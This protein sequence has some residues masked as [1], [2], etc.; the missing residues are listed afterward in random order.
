MTTTALPHPTP[1][2]LPV[3]WHALPHFIVFE[4]TRLETTRPDRTPKLKKRPLIPSTTDHA[5][6]TRPQTWRRYDQAVADLTRRGAGPYGVDATGHPI[7]GYAL[8]FAITRELGVTLADF[9]QRAEHPLIAQLNSFTERSLT[10]GWHVL[11]GGHPPDHFVARGDVEVYPGARFTVLTGLL[12]Y[13][14]RIIHDRAEILVELFP[15]R[16]APAPLPPSPVDLNDEDV[17]AAVLRMPLAGRLY[18]SAELCG[19]PSRSEGDLGLLNGMVKAGVTD[20]DRLDTLFRGSA[21]MRPEWDRRS[22][23]ETTLRKALNGYVQA[24][25]PMPSRNGNGHHCEDVANFATSSAADLT[26]EPEMMPD[27]GIIGGDTAELIAELRAAL[28]AKSA[29]FTAERTARLAAEAKVSDL[30]TQLAARDARLETLTAVQSLQARIVGNR[31]LGAARNTHATVGTLLAWRATA[32][33]TP[34]AEWGIP[35]PPGMVAAKVK[36]IAQLSGVTAKTAG[37]HLQGM[38]D[39]GRLR[40]TILTVRERINPDTGEILPL[41][42][43]LTVHC[44]GLPNDLPL[45]PENVLAFQRSLADYHPEKKD[46]RGGKRIPR[47]PI[48]PHAG[49]LQT[50]AYRCAEASCHRLLAGP[51]TTLVPAM[52]LAPPPD[53]QT[54]PIRDEP[55]EEGDCGDNDEVNARARSDT[56]S[57]DAVPAIPDGQTLPIREILSEARVARPHIVYAPETRGATHTQQSP[58]VDVRSMAVLNLPIREDPRRT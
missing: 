55:L 3:G 45:T 22:Y 44:I 53:G 21:R 30:T 49:V 13:G 32:D 50:T 39:A 40:R 54:L 52:L 8:G 25:D 14:R 36:D 31:S 23:R 15:A 56:R 46:P 24:R 57:G 5:S 4:V 48:H 43:A 29:A 33:A 26:P 2:L 18:R 27:A 38:E 10:G 7:V 34:P 19:Y 11:V 17:I 35:I 16:P 42:Q 47:C 37:D 58:P 41:E 12:A 1:E 6:I 28:A 9:D 51:D 20:P